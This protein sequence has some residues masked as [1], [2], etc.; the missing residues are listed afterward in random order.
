MWE[1]HLAY[2]VDLL[3]YHHAPT[4][5]NDGEFGVEYLYRQAGKSFSYSLTPVD[6]EIMNEMDKGFVDESM[7]VPSTSEGVLMVGAGA[8]GEEEEEEEEESETKTSNV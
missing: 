3:P 4:Q 2:N 8:P 7:A 5:H 6:D 1:T